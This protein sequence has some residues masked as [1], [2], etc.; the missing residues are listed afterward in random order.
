[1]HIAMAL[2]SFALLAR[3]SSG[4]EVLCRTEFHGSVPLGLAD[5]DSYKAEAVFGVNVSNVSEQ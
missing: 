4:Y 3:G 2:L 5:A 1:M